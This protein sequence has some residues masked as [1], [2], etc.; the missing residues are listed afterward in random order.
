MKKN[1]NVRNLIITMLCITIICMGI[2]FAYLS[3]KL[4]TKNNEKHI[5][6]VSFTKVITQTPVKGGFVSPNSQNEIIN[7]GKTLNMTFNLYTPRDELAYTIIVKNEGT[8]PVKI[9]DVLT[10]PNYTEQEEVAKT[11]FPIKITHNDLSNKVLQPEQEL[12]I[13]LV[14]TYTTEA[15]VGQMIIPYQLTLVTSSPERK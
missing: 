4:D 12:E 1:T 2:G 3:V 10:Y 11:I 13:K 7:D 15:N 9:T 6:D 14:T 8:L 5:F